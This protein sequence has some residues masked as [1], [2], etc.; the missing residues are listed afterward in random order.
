MGGF[1]DYRRQP[2][3]ERLYRDFFGFRGKRSLFPEA[4]RISDKGIS[5]GRAGRSGGGKGKNRHAVCHF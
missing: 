4:G 3:G 1:R 5:A 2:P